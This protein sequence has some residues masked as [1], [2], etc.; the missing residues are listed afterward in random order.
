MALPQVNY[1]FR[2]GRKEKSE[3]RNPGILSVDE[4]YEFTAHQCNKDRNFWTY[5]YKFS[6]TPKIKCPAKARVIYFGNK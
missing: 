4:K 6:L 2:P 5:A 3:T 1:C